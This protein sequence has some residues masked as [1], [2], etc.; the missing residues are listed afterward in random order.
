MR[1]SNTVL[2]LGSA[3]FMSLLSQCREN[4]GDY[5]ARIPSR[6][7]S[8]DEFDKVKPSDKVRRGEVSD[9]VQSYNMPKVTVQEVTKNTYYKEPTAK[10]T[11]KL[12]DSWQGRTAV[13]EE[14]RLRDT[15]EWTSGKM[16]FFLA[17]GAVDPVAALNAARNSDR[18]SITVSTTAALQGWASVSPDAARGW[19]DAQP[20]NAERTQYV[21][22][23]LES[24][25]IKDMDAVAWEQRGS[26][27]AS[28]VEL[29]GIYAVLGEQVSAW[30]EVDHEGA[31]RWVEDELKDSPQRQTIIDQ[32][33]QQ[34]FATDEALAKTTEWLQGYEKGELRDAMLLAYVKQAVYADTAVA[35]Q[36]SNLIED[37][38]LKKQASAVCESSAAIQSE[39]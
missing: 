4:K 21:R 17:W 26:W 31:L 11:G 27:L 5:N 29:P 20:V 25:A 36:W 33:M 15:N 9:G 2:I 19:V 39:E 7:K 28:Q 13:D 16:E 38:D 37:E 14:K 32:W 24:E 30:S 8:T 10:A 35:K 18:G 23:L 22:A 34:N 3:F 12:P 1:I 6:G